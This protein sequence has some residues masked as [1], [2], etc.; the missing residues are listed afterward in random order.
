MREHGVRKLGPRGLIERLWSEEPALQALLERSK[1]GE[2][3]RERI[4][5]YLE[6]LESAVRIGAFDLDRIERASALAWIHAFKEM[7]S[8]ENEAVAGFST[9]DLLWRAARGETDELT[10]S[11]VEE[12]VHVFRAISGGSGLGRG[13]MRLDG[14]G[15]PFESLP[16]TG[17]RGALARSRFL[18]DVAADFWEGV[19]AHPSGLDDEVVRARERNREK[20][21]GYFNAEDRD[22]ERAEWQAANVLKGER[23]LRVL[24][25]LVPLASEELAAIRLSVQ[26]RLP[27]GI[28]PYYLSLFDLD[29]A[30][31][32]VDG[33]VRSQ[34]IPT[35]HAVSAMIEHREDRKRAFDFMRER[36]TSPADR[37]IRR[38][39]TVAVFKVC[40][41]CPQVC[42]YCQRNW[43]ID[44]AMETDRLPTRAELEPGMMWLEEH[45]AIADVL[46]TGGDPLVLDDR[47]IADLLERLARMEHVRHV[48]IGTRVPVTMPMRVSETLAGILGAAS[49]PG[50]RT[51]SV[52]TH[53]ESAYE[54]T[55]DL[56]RAVDR[57]RRCGVRVYNQQV[58]TVEASRRFQP[59]ATR[60]ALVRAGV[61]PYYT[62]YAKGKEEHRDYLVPIAR[63]LQERK[64]EA[65]LLP[66]VFRTDE[67]VFN[68]PGLG[69]SHLR[70]QQDR[71]LIGIRSDGRRV[72]VFHPWEKG[73][74]P[75]APWPY[76]DVSIAGYLDRIEAIGECRED[77]ASIWY[78]L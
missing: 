72:Y 28:T 20:I 68:V 34:V 3:A 16:G 23:G 18:D 26:Y 32:A 1:T 24:Q 53:V 77:Y 66:G 7:A 42:T 37:I 62:F 31:R 5:S 29:S 73:I 64:E 60:I 39:P 47:V 15:E 65:R 40:G 70:A 14:E 45:S 69:K 74:A 41:T 21:L 36:D 59:S 2:E 13:W 50:R 58:L 30:D 17:R 46:L 25:D 9:M 76:V 27:W 43:E 71:E 57:L 55:P 38:Y 78:Y 33:Q 52:V 51:L 8:P 61:D 11:F 54:V 4:L 10:E 6:D 19:G 75:V 67:P 48:R 12:F 35:V 63:L 56:A 22:W 49:E 44:D